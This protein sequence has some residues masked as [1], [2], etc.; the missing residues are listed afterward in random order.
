MDRKS[1][2]LNSYLRVK[3]FFKKNKKGTYTITNIRDKLQIDFYS[4][5]IIIDQLKKD[6]FIRKNGKRYCWR[7]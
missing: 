1:P 2:T 5:S 6:K 4:V 7:N 3:E